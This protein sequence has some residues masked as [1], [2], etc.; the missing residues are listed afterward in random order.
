MPL[1]PAYKAGLVGHLP[2]KCQNACLTISSIPGRNPPVAD[3]LHRLAFPKL[4]FCS[5]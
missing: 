3:R 5:K 2:V 1:D 4:A